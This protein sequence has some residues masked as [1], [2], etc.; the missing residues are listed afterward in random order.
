MA[1]TCFTCGEDKVSEP[2]R[3]RIHDDDDCPIC[4]VCYDK[5]FEEDEEED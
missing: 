4:D 3:F 5:Q 1:L 2:K